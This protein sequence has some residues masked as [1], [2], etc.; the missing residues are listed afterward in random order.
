MDRNHV[1]TNRKDQL[2]LEAAAVEVRV[3]D[4]ADPETL[5]RIAG[6]AHDSAFSYEPYG[7]LR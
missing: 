4:L 7:R 1:G 2:F 5:A 3:S 6:R